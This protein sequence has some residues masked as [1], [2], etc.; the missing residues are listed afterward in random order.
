VPPCCPGVGVALR[1]QDYCGRLLWRSLR[2]PHNYR[3]RAARVRRR[4]VLI[5]CM[6]GCRMLRSALQSRPG[7]RPRASKAAAA[8]APGE[9]ATYAV[10]AAPAE[11]SAPA[12]EKPARKRGRPSK[13][14]NIW[15][16]IRYCNAP[17]PAMLLP[18]HHDWIMG[19]S[20]LSPAAMFYISMVPGQLC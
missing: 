10:A 8:A 2:H 14:G 7:R 13:A 4:E 12:A 9:A 1:I 18:A 5:S 20:L 16:P 11:Q 17:L 15:L 19:M 6:S 3:C